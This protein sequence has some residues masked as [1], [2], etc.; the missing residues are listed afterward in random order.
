M[1]E[2]A[3]D[4]RKLD[5]ADTGLRKDG[6]VL[7]LE[8]R[9]ERIRNLQR[10]SRRIVDIDQARMQR[11]QED[12]QH[13]EAEAILETVEEMVMVE[14]GRKVEK[15]QIQIQ[16][17]V[18]GVIDGLI[19]L[20]DM[21]KKMQKEYRQEIHS[22]VK[23]SGLMEKLEAIFKN[24][25]EAKIGFCIRSFRQVD[26]TKP[27]NMD[28]VQDELDAV[29]MLAE[30]EGIESP[31][32]DEYLDNH[33]KQWENRLKT[34]K[35]QW[36]V[37]RQE[38][39]PVAYSEIES[40]REMLYTDF[41]G[42]MIAVKLLKDK[43]SK[44]SPSAQENWNEYVRSS[45]ESRLFTMMDTIV[46]PEFERSRL[47]LELEIIEERIDTLESRD[48]KRI[49][50]IAKRTE[51]LR[52]KNTFED[53]FKDVQEFTNPGKQEEQK[54][55]FVKAYEEYADKGE[56]AWDEAKRQAAHRSDYG[57]FNRHVKKLVSD[58]DAARY[59]DEIKELNEEA[60]KAFELSGFAGRSIESMRLNPYPPMGPYESYNDQLDIEL[61]ALTGK[62]DPEEIFVEK[63]L[64]FLYN[65]FRS[66]FRR[67]SSLTLADFHAKRDLI[68]KGKENRIR[69]VCH[70]AVTLARKLKQEH[71]VI[72][73][74]AVM[75]LSVPTR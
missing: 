32:V 18:D 39:S 28:E 56:Q 57:K 9:L 2:V 64:G 44:E 10:Q 49:I 19:W 46:T 47:K 58:E 4:Y 30:R 38:L 27:R 71:K 40:V 66:D 22:L 53:Q 1:G 13:A 26:D 73:R 33:E 75:K 21:P 6:S 51:L 48:P 42:F 24:T 43:M 8:A 35:G 31:F 67:D 29:R 59:K 61:G 25:N 62:E 68:S 65:K 7:D 60:K 70:D 23:D 17:A 12:E 69:G 3:L 72:D 37:L 54:G 15:G 55:K 11:D 16:E 74:K 5:Q 14:L 50:L 63:L 34:D 20:N 41:E 45:L 36:A 52:R